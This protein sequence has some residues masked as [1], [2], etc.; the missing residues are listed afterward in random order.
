MLIRKYRG[1]SIEEIQEQFRK[2]LGP[3]ALIFNIRQVKHKGLK[4]LFASPQFEA[5]VAVENEH[6]EELK[7][8][9]ESLRKIKLILTQIAC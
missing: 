4:K 1:G 5:I 3:E 2:E 8:E 6:D 7:K 9:I